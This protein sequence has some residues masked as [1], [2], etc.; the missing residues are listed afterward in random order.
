MSADAGVLTPGSLAEVNT[1]LNE[2]KNSGV[3]GQ[4]A[5]LGESAPS[6]QLLC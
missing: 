3:L 4:V 1:Q 6:L 5:T 2:S